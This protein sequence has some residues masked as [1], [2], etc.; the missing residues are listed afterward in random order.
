MTIFLKESI[1][2]NCSLPKNKDEMITAMICCNQNES[3]TI[4]QHGQ[5][6]SNHFI[7][8]INHLKGIDLLNDWKMPNWIYDYKDKLI[9]SMHDEEKIKE[10]TIYHDCGKPYCRTVDYLGKVHFPNHEIVSSYVWLSIGGDV[11]VGRLIAD[12][13]VIHTA[14][15]I[16]IED[17][18]NKWS[19]QDA[20]TL[21]LAALAEVHSNSKMFGGIE[22]TSFKMKWKTVD[23]RGKQICKFLFKN[24][25][26]GVFC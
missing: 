24:Q 15:A 12:D 4:Y 20:V 16:E 13:M 18:L 19:C 17:K 9:E 5:S 23:K 21:L 3:Q 2:I 14:T 8:L 6:V 22:S 26:K 25:E 1:G 11:D 10:Y 7:D